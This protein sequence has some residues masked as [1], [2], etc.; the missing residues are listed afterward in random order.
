MLPLVSNSVGFTIREAD[1]RRHLFEN[2]KRNRTEVAAE[3]DQ[4]LQHSQ[5]LW[6]PSRVCAKPCQFVDSLF[7]F[8]DH[9]YTEIVQ[10]DIKSIEINN[11]EGREECKQNEQY[12]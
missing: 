12:F 11:Q 3:P 9:L 1:S 6:Y 10:I 7:L 8:R 2:K 4:R 5:G